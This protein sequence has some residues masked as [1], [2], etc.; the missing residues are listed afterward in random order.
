MNRA[1]A[2]IVGA[3]VEAWAELRIH[4][5]RV[6]LSLIGI[7][8]AVCALT[9]V[10]GAGAL[11]TQAQTESA[12][13]NQGRPAMISLSAYDS[14]TGMAVESKELDDAFDAA[15]A[16][17]EIGYAARSTYVEAQVQF[18]DGVRYVYGQAVDAD[19]GTMHRM[20]VIEGRWFEESDNNRFA[21]AVLINEKFWELLGSPDL[22]T[23]PTFSMLGETPVTAV[24]IGITPSPSPFAEPQMTML[25]DDWAPLQTPEHLANNGATYELWVPPELAEEML[26]LIEAD[27]L[28]S[29][30]DQDFEVQVNRNDYLAYSDGDPLLGLKLAVGGVAGLVLL[31]GAL[32]LVNIALVTVRQRI[33][34]I[35]IRRSFGATAGR[36]FFA[37]MMESVVASVAAGVIGVALAVAIVQSPLVQDLLAE[38]I[39]DVPPFP[40]E[41][42]IIGLASSAFVGALAGLLP[43]LVAVRVK[44]IDAIRY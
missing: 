20:S 2:S 5:T 14:Q 4:R 41:A 26:P 33:R 12:E 36:V 18:A 27:V 1:L 29:L 8:V 38:G 11:L 25:F 21:P 17:Y 3:V 30:G 34:E 39:I 42:A 28:G 35:G 19:Y 6:L 32:G 10:V 16:R 22:A 43:A 44:V 9:V 40:V 37:V 31:L 24:V 23:H 15:I 7:A 13:R